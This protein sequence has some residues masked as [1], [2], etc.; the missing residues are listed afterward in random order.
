VKLLRVFEYGASGTTGERSYWTI[1]VE[2]NQTAAEVA[3]TVATKCALLAGSFALFEVTV[4]GKNERR[5]GDH[6]RRST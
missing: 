2:E 3:D 5:L 1:K 6:E 4:D